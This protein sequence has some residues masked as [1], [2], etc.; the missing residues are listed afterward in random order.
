MNK[1]ARLFLMVAGTAI[2][3]QIYLNMF[4]DGFIIAMSVVM[5]GFFLY[6]FKDIEPL[7]AVLLIAVFSPLF[8]LFIML[9][10]GNPVFESILL[11]LPDVSFFIAYAIFFGA[12]F[13]SLGYISYRNYYFRLALCDFFSNCVE[14]FFRFLILHTGFDLD[15]L[16]GLIVLAMSRSLLI[17]LLCMASDSYRSLLENREH[18][19]NYKKLVLMAATFNAEVYFMQKN[20]NEI[21]SI[22]T[23]AFSLYKGLNRLDDCPR[24]FSTS[25]LGIAKDIHEVKKGYRRVIQGLQN[26]FLA[27]FENNRLSLKDILKILSVDVDKSA[28]SPNTTV[29]FSCSIANDYL[30]EKHFAF[31]SILRNLISNSID[32]F[33]SSNQFDGSISVLCKETE[34]DGNRFCKIVVRDNGPGIDENAIGFLFEPG[35]TTKY[36]E[37]GDQNR[38]LGLTLVKDLIREVFHGDISVISSTSGTSFTILIPVTYLTENFEPISIKDDDETITYTDNYEQQ[39]DEL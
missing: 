20:M 28:A 17:L 38:G 16:G 3:S 26:N 33:E 25:A 36:D 1:K 19:E 27:E 2:S 32:A 11:V 24:E 22:M 37:G 23:E 29:S 8:R 4:V 6:I 31:M 30:I 12:V 34:I 9:M 5:T 10:R 7:K 13:R 15:K 21:E 14:M 39:E 35:Y 18:E